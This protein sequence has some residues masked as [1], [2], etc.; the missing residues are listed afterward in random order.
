[1]NLN[2]KKVGAFHKLFEDILLY[3]NNE[4]Y[5]K[6]FPNYLT[7]LLDNFKGTHDSSFVDAFLEVFNET[8]EVKQSSLTEYMLRLSLF[9]FLNSVL[10]RI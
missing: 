10:V 1:M 4:E 5:N 3:F 7:K 9:L 2:S 6:Y 8:M